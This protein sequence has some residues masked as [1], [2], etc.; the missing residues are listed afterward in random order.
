M[1]K[2]PLQGLTIAVTRPRDQAVQLA[3]RIEQAGGTS[4]LFPLLEISAVRDT[5]LIQEQ[6]SRLGEFSFAIFISP[7]AVK[8]GVAAIRSLGA[9]PESIKIATVGQGSVRA[10]YDLGITNVIAPKERFDSEGLLALPEMQDVAGMRILIFRGDAGREL[11]GDT[12]RERGAVVEYVSCYQR[13]KTKPDVHILLEG[14]LDAIS[15]TSSEAM[16]HLWQMLGDSEKDDL[17]KVPLFVQHERIAGLAGEQGWQHI[18]L[19][20]PGDDGLMSA[21]VEWGSNERT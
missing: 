3:Q 14:K 16:S 19:T 9:I 11:L 5:Q 15:V 4:L 17:R 18:H 20:G 7:N 8:Y 12:L 6:I 2:P 21:L 10:L 13:R 1:A